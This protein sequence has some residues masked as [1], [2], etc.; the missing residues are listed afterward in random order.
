[1]ITKV[2]D[3][4]VVAESY[5]AIDV[6]SCGSS[7]HERNCGVASTGIGKTVRKKYM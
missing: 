1:M 6:P 7:F 5:K 3:F 4:W 2:V